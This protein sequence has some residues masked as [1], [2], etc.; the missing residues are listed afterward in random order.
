V[1]SVGVH[2]RGIGVN[3]NPAIDR[4]YVANEDSS[5][6]S[7]INPTTFAVTTIPVSGNPRAVGVN[8][9]T[10]RVY[11]TTHSNVVAIDGSANSVVDTIP[12]GPQAYGVAVN[13]N[14]AV[15]RVY[16]SSF[17]GR[18]VSV[19][20]DPTVCN[21]TIEKQAVPAT[22][23]GFAFESSNPG[24]HG[25]T[26]DHGE[27]ATEQIPCGSSV[28][29]FEA[30]PP[31]GWTLTN[32]T[33]SVSSGAGSFTFGN[34]TT[35]HIGGFQAGDTGV[36]I[37]PG[38]VSSD[39][40]CTFTN[41]EFAC[42]AGPGGLTVNCIAVDVD[43][44]N[45]TNANGCPSY[46]CSPGVL[47]PTEN[48][49]AVVSPSS[50][51]FDIDIVVDSSPVGGSGRS[52]MALAYNPTVVNIAARNSSVSLIHQGPG[53]TP[54]GSFDP[55]P[56]TDGL[57]VFTDGDFQA[58]GE[59]GRG[60]VIRLTI[61]PVGVGSSPLV[62]VPNLDAEPVMYDTNGNPYD[63]DN[64]GIR[65]GSIFVGSACPEA[66]LTGQ[67]FCIYGSSTGVAWQWTVGSFSGIT[68]VP[69]GDNASAIASAWVSSMNSAFTGGL[70]AK[71]LK[72]STHCFIFTPGGQTL[73]VN[74]V[75]LGN[76]TITTTNGCSFNPAVF[77]ISS[78]GGIAELR[79]SDAGGETAAGPPAST[80]SFPYVTVAGSLA[81]GA[82]ALLAA[83]GWY[84]R[85]RY[86]MTRRDW[87]G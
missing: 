55:T 74:T 21:V 23:T 4:V 64:R 30:Q 22:G 16:A 27:S 53:D 84:G 35:V 19:I 77:E 50:P 36:T 29:V 49:R 11:V 69:I 45:N 15:D 54:Y 63:T 26:L 56:D 24:L 52:D 39:L 85:R 82:A 20:A 86:M 60:I 80:S 58:D 13:A 83:A 38:L 71:I 12:V 28:N 42:G 75:G 46:P 10:G 14:P 51:N 78:V 31:P 6:V 67:T 72:L 87:Q 79:V 62:L 34:Q 59:G 1:A 25:I 8:S 68:S 44:T 32:V 57:Y 17:G 33:C 3:A 18:T 9:Q 37:S 7:V 2:P 73:T 47:G 43:P 41:T 66:N 76:C 48:C 70:Q 61:D 40:E 65:N 5:S 81:F